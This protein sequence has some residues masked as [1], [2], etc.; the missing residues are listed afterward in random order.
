[1]ASRVRLP[2]RRIGD[3]KIQTNSRGSGRNANTATVFFELQQSEMN[4]TKAVSPLFFAPFAPFC[5]H[6]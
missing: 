5:G 3:W 6:K 4:F 1:V 2:D